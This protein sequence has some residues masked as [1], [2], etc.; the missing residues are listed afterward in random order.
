MAESLGCGPKVT[1]IGFIIELYDPYRKQEMV[2]WQGVKMVK[3]G[4]AGPLPVPC[5]S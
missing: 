1:I 2:K 5:F 4:S 3:T